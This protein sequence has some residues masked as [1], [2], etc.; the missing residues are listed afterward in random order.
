MTKK[1]FK[2]N[3]EM[4]RKCSLA[5]RGHKP[6]LLKHTEQTRLKISKAKK[7]KC[8]TEEHKRKLS[9]ALKGHIVTEETRRKMGIKSRLKNKGLTSL[10]LLIRQTE[11][12]KLWRSKV[13]ERD[14]YTCQNCRKRGI[15]LE[16]H[17]I[18]R[19]SY[20]LKENNIFSVE[21]A[22]NCKELWN[23]D[24]GVILCK[25]CHNLT[26]GRRKNYIGNI[27]DINI[28]TKEMIGQKEVKN[29]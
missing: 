28:E 9:S 23:L 10:H 6:T 12:Y 7:G 18:K 17:H 19:F 25:E 1:G 22:L 27:Y 4:K 16:C 5:K 14:F 29:E 13:F 26:K 8:F 24:N 3:E 2:H 20:I 15:Y 21:Q 11:K